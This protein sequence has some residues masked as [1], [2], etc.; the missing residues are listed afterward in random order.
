MLDDIHHGDIWINGMNGP[1][2]HYRYQRLPLIGD[3]N[4]HPIGR[5][6]E[7]VVFHHAIGLIDV[8]SEVIKPSAV[9]G[10][11]RAIF[12]AWNRQYGGRECHQHE[13]IAYD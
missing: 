10:C 5:V 2:Q 7:A 4:W 8:H 6:G 3:T 11:E 13:Q 1:V 12:L 9:R